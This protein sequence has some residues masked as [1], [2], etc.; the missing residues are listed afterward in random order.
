MYSCL[1]A[2]RNAA[3]LWFSFSVA[4]T[5]EALSFKRKIRAFR[6]GSRGNLFLLNAPGCNRPGPQDRE[7][8]SAVPLTRS[9]RGPSS[10]ETTLPCLSPLLPSQSP[11]SL[12]MARPSDWLEIVNRPQT[13][14]ELAALRRC[15]SRGRPF[16]TEAWV[17]RIAK[18]LGLESALSP[19]GRP[20][21]SKMKQPEK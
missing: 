15:V 16:G 7:S 20:R 2:F 17:R 12:V 3:S 10:D 14:D 6:T 1:C 4:A 19:R 9:R 8:A 5:S 21:K 13:D 18:K 11:F